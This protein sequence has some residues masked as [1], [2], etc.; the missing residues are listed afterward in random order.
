MGIFTA[1]FPVGSM[2]GGMLIDGRGGIARNGRALALGQVG[3]AFCIATIAVGLPFAGTAAAVLGWG[4]CGAFFIN[5]GRT[6]F[7]E[8]ASE[9]NRARVL[10][11]YTLG[12]MGGAPFGSLIAGLLA[13][14]LGLHGTLALDAALSLAVTLGVVTTTRV[15]SL[16]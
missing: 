11:V 3:A 10:S 13:A 7:Q 6:I 1:M 14:P 2:L 12:V 5:S 16:R 9:A 4:L 15:Y 8:N